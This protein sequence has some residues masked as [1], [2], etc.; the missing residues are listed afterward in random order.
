MY[1]RAYVCM[2]AFVCVYVCGW[3]VIRLLISNKFVRARDYIGCV[4]ARVCA[5]ETAD[6]CRDAFSRVRLQRRPYLSEVVAAPC[7]LPPFFGCVR[8]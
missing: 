4:H 6:S 7:W 8:L 1:K 2:R 5:Y 3:W